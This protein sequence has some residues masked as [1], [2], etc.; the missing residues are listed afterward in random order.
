MN[1]LKTDGERTLVLCRYRDLW[2]FN[3]VQTSQFGIRKGGSL[4]QRIT[5]AISW[6]LPDEN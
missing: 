2:P 4:T 1:V 5:V 6:K 3:S